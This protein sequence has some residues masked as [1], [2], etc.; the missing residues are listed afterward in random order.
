MDP[1]KGQGT[2]PGSGVR[3]QG[4]FMPGQLTTTGS[5]G[6][7]PRAEPSAFTPPQISLAARWRCNTGNRREYQ[8]HL[9]R[10]GRPRIKNQTLS[11]YLGQLRDRFPH[12]KLRARVEG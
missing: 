5:R 8:T 7:G 3:R 6:D 2:R 9:Q 4:K 10:N 12:T 1:V 11:V